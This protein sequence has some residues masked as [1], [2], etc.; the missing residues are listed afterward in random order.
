MK[1]ISKKKEV[2]GV[3][4]PETL[5]AARKHSQWEKFW[6]AMNTE[7]ASFHKK[8]AWRLVPKPKGAHVVSTRWVF[9]VKQKDGAID[10]FKARL[11]ARGYTQKEG[12][13]YSLQE[14]Y[15][16]TMKGKTLRMLM[17]LA[18][19]DDADVR[20]FDISVAFLHA[21]LEETVYVSQ[22]EGFVVEGKEDWVY[23]LDKAMYGLKQSPRAFGKHL[24]KCLVKI[25]FKESEADECLYIRRW[26]DGTYCYLVYHVDDIITVASNKKRRKQVFQALQMCE[27]DIRDEGRADR[28]LGLQFEY[29][30]EY[31]SITQE[32]Y[33]TKCAEQFNCA[34]GGAMHTPGRAEK[35]H[36]LSKADLPQT[37]EEER[38]ASLLPYPA[39][40]GSL[41]YA[42]KTRPDVAFAVSELSQ[43]M[44]RWGARTYAQAQRVLRYLYHTRHRAL[45]YK[46][47][48]KS[49]IEIVCY[50]DANYGD[51]RDTGN[52]DK[53][54]SQGGHVVYVAG[55]L[56][57]WSSKRH[58]CVTLSSMEAEYVE[59]TKGGQEI[60]WWRRLLEDLGFPQNRPSV[61]REDNKACIAFSLNHTQHG[62]SKHIDI[63]LHW[64]RKIVQSKQIDMEHVATDD[65]VAD[66]MTKHLRRPKHDRFTSML[67]DGAEKIDK[68]AYICAACN[69]IEVLC[70][71]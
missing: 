47:G 42:C 51:S 54:C 68:P 69:T 6:E 21:L 62:R 45:R 34:D 3:T 36:A 10:R 64:L 14:L 12:V 28:F 39:L 17:L 37:A 40:C 63:R 32:H 25:G 67:Y 33:I 1:N 43:Y 55:Q 35:E 13:D 57:A 66:I 2:C 5:R 44:S 20:Q 41:L 61:L 53:W 9:D 26:K 52:D 24:A 22:P 4:V 16:P 58:R 30:D 29:D 48:G 56:V 71:A 7:F 50:A 49:E 18:A 31:I 23:V 70:A 60:L 15:A 65:M 19:R 11:V 38:A 59:A 8:K 27:L 46:R